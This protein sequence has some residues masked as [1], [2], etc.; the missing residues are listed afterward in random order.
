MGKLCQ[1]NPFTNFYY[2]MRNSTSIRCIQFIFGWVLVAIFYNYKHCHEEPTNFPL[3]W[4]MRNQRISPQC[5][6]TKYKRCILIH[7]ELLSL[8]NDSNTQSLE[9]MQ[10]KRKNT[11]QDICPWSFF[12][13]SWVLHPTTIANN[14]AC[15]PFEY[16]TLITN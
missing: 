9:D 15:I 13:F 12:P 6:L 4:S 5:G 8:D 14:S 7:F 3:M 16:E 11:H 2:F 1:T 10:E